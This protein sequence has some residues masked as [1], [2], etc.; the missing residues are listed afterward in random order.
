MKKNV[1]AMFV[2]AIIAS[3][4]MG[5]AFAADATDTVVNG[6]TVYFK[7]TVVDAACSVTSGNDGDGQTVAL[8]QVR[9][10]RLAEAGK[11]ANQKQEFH[12]DLKDC[13]PAV[14]QNAAV[15]FNAQADGTVV[16]AM[17][18]TAGAGAASNVALQLFGPDGKALAIGDESSA[19]VIDSATV[20]IPLSVD[21]VATAAAATP[22]DV[23]ATATFKIHYS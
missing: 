4:A 11:F 7:G 18:N 10:A 5:S 22:G 15:I 14:S 13:D 12:I 3:A 23:E 2:T 8:D 16:G 17:A 21:Y 9:T 6:G 20:R 1:I 19:V